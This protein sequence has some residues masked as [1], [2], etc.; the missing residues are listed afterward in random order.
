MNSRHLSDNEGLLVSALIN[1]S[2]SK[3]SYLQSE[4][5]SIA[6]SE[7]DDGGMGSLKFGAENEDDRQLGESICEAEFIDDDGVAVS[8]ALNVD[9]QGRLYELDI[10]KVDFSKLIAIPEVDSVTFMKPVM[11][12]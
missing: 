7:I 10:W 11:V 5:S 12:K 2:A 1:A 3:W 4:V 6:V 8:V 9:R